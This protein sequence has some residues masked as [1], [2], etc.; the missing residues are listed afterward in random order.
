MYICI[1]ACIYFDII[2]RHAY[3]YYIYYN[4]LYFY[5]PI[6]VSESCASSVAIL[7]QRCGEQRRNS[8]VVEPE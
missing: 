3:E 7:V 6:L 1:Y 2:Y 4:Y 8:M 5:A